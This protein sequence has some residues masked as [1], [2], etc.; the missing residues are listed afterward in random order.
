[1]AKQEGRSRRAKRSMTGLDLAVLLRESWVKVEGAL[2]SKVHQVGESVELRLR[3]KTR[4]SL[5]ATPPT[6]LLLTRLELTPPQVP[7]SFARA[8]RE[9]LQGSRV[10]SVRQL[11]LDRVVMIEVER[12]DASRVT[13]VYEGVREGNLLAVKNGVIVAALRERRMKDRDVIVGAHYVPPPARGLDPLS[14]TEEDL[15]QIVGGRGKLITLLSRHVNAPGEVIAEAIYRSGADPYG[16]PKSLD[17]SVFLDALKDVLLEALKNRRGFVVFEEGLSIG[18][19]PF[20]PTHLAEGREIEEVESF[21]KAAEKYFIEILEEKLREKEGIGPAAVAL[22]KAAKY[23]ER[24][25]RLRE[26]AEYIFANIGRFERLLARARE[27]RSEGRLSDIAAEYPE[28]AGIDFASGVIKVKVGDMELEFSLSESAAKAAS[29]L[30]EGAKRLERKAA[31]AREI[32]PSLGRLPREVRSRVFRVR[33]EEAWYSQFLH[34][35]SSEGFLVVGGRNATQN[36]ILVKKYLEP[37]DLF[38]HADIHGGPVVIVKTGG[39]M[40]G[41]KTILQAAQ[42]A[43][44]FSRAWELGFHQIRVYWVY[45]KQVSKRAPS[46]EYLSKGAFMVHGKRNYV[47]VPLRVSVGVR[48]ENGT[49]GLVYGPPSAVEA[50]C[51]AMVELAPGR[52]ERDLVAKKIARFL[53][54][55]MKARGIFI[56]ISP[57]DILRCLPRGGFYV[58]RRVEVG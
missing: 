22:E 28:V 45:G 29:R 49:V 31:R 15:R 4:L 44:A 50:N 11:G 30:Y 53:V 47:K 25:S 36:E 37:E 9:Y 51:T 19:Y 54:E 16:D 20:E 39:R 18:V 48:L 12:L 7:P 52:I 17:P 1:M 6:A 46:G 40:P 32:A 26:A 14:L 13:F 27:L 33:R 21:S 41:G 24:A 2:V 38:F 5:V 34:F 8:L 42:L 23:E 10:I 43:A 56:K 55:T 35:T 3:G 57:S 58:V